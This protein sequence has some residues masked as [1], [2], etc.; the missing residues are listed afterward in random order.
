MNSIYKIKSRYTSNVKNIYTEE[1]DTAD[2]TQWR[3]IK[4][5]RMVERWFKILCPHQLNNIPITNDYTDNKRA[6]LLLNMINAEIETLNIYNKGQQER[7]FE[8]TIEEIN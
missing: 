3:D 6:E 4:Y 5:N 7:K 2:N 8:I 1:I